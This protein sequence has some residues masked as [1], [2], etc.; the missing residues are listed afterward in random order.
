MS[1]IV[2]GIYKKWYGRLYLIY[3]GK[4]GKGFLGVKCWIC[5]LE[6]E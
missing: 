4:Y 1:V 2:G 3:K 6:D 5:I